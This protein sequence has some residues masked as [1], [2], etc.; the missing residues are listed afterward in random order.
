MGQKGVVFST[1][2]STKQCADLF[3]QAA[4]NARGL[5]AVVSELSAKAMGNDQSGFFTPTFDSPFAG[6]DGIPDFAVGVYIGKMLNGASGAGTAV[7]MYV[8]EDGDHRSVQ[9]VSPHT[10]MGGMRSAKFAR[11]FLEAFQAADPNLRIS[12]GNVQAI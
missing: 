8:D 10:M 2:M 7:H 1:A 11:K 5:G 9:I 12:D 6:I 3:R 4:G